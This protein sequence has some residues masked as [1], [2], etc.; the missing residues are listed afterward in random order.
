[1]TILDID[2]EKWLIIMSAFEYAH[3]DSKHL[4]CDEFDKLHRKYPNFV[5]G[6]RRDDGKL[7]FSCSPEL[8][9]KIRARILPNH[10]W[11]KL[12]IVPPANSP[13]QAE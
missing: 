1:M 13:T 6:V 12:R 9:E 8:E 2:G 11:R 4:A 5:I 7:G 3:P 10:K